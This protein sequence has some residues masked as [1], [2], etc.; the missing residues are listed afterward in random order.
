MSPAAQ[1]PGAHI[2]SARLKLQMEMSNKAGALV[3][4]GMTNRRLP[5]LRETDTTAAVKT[6]IRY[7]LAAAITL[8]LAVTTSQAQS[9]NILFGA[10]GGGSLTDLYILNPANGSVLVD[11]GPTGF[12]ITG[13][14]FDP[15]TGVLYGS[16]ANRLSAG[17]LITLNPIT[18]TGT[19]VGNFGV[20]NHTMADL[21][22]TKDG[23]LYGWAE[24]SRDDLHI[25]NKAT[26]A[27]TDVGNAGLSTFGSGL[28]ANS[29]DVLYFTGSGPNGPLRIV[30]KNTGLTTVVTNM[31]GAP[32]PGGSINAL[33]FDSH[34]V[35]YA[36]NGGDFGPNSL[37]KRHGR[38]GVSF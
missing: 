21:A 37:A 33:A 15:T 28:A 32:L 8:F 13:L 5:R 36:I 6:G 29:Q 23:T 10:R 20:P 17:D 11:L 31:S 16:T 2:Q 4:A 7:A 35:L 24:P 3:R 34:N 12:S 14:R 9:R 25:I 18:G 1:Q 27:A 30:D 19:F 22:F 26:G 38:A